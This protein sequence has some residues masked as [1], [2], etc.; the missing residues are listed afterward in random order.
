MPAVQ[1]VQQPVKNKDFGDADSGA[2]LLTVEEQKALVP[3]KDEVPPG[4][5][6]F[7]ELTDEGEPTGKVKAQ[8]TPGKPEAAVQVVGPRIY[9]EVTTPA[10][11]P[12][13]T[14]MQPNPDHYD[15]EFAR[16]NPVEQ[17]ESRDRK[18]TKDRSPPVSGKAA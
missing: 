12:L 8:K 17:R 2:E 7:V 15:V 6:G 3:G 10:G 14:N 18:G 16:R 11:A 9:D 5:E 4:G 1:G 13:T